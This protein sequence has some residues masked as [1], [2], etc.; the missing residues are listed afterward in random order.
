MTSNVRTNSKQLVR[1]DESPGSTNMKGE[2]G[3]DS[4]TKQRPWS[5]LASSEDEVRGS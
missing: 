2:T 5:D 3:R 1:T 4:L